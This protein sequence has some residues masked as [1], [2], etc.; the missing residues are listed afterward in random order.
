MLDY[1]M[2]TFL[3]LCETK[4]YTRTAECL[5]LTQPSVTQHIKYLEQFYQCQ[6]FRY[7]G[8]RVELTEAGQ[9]LQDKMILQRAR[10]AEIRKRLNR[11]EE[12]VLLDIGLTPTVAFSPL[13]KPLCPYMH[14]VADPRVK[15]HV[16]DTRQLLRR[17]QNGMLDAVIVEGDIPDMLVEAT[18]LHR[19]K[20]IA[21]TCPALAEQLY[22]CTWQQLMHQPLILME[23]G[24]GLRTL[25]QQ[26]LS[27]RG[28]SLYDFADVLEVDSFT[29]LKEQLRQGDGIAFLFESTVARERAEHDLK[30]IYID[31][32]SMYG[33]IYFVSMR[34]RL[35]QEPLVRLRDALAAAVLPQK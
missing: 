30:R 10:D 35:E 18:E 5:H 13:L 16:A 4:S 2:D 17:M 33:T 31:T 27:S 15:L 34:E 32:P 20:I 29:I 21:A 11:L 25:V 22:G 6:L 12:D 1:R 24:C 14:T 19:E 8:R 23:S 28:I 26:N 9:Y 7:D 3:S